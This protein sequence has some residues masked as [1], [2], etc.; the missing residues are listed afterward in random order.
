MDTATGWRTNT[1]TSG[2]RPVS[3]LSPFLVFRHKNRSCYLILK[4]NTFFFILHL[5]S[6]FF[7][8]TDFTCKISLWANLQID[9]T[10][11]KAD[12]NKNKKF[13]QEKELLL[14]SVSPLSCFVSSFIL[15][16]QTNEWSSCFQ[17]YRKLFNVLFS[18]KKRLD[19]CLSLLQYSDK[20]V[21]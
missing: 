14:V 1:S 3:S 10:N 15:L 11:E 19:F 5:I 6:F 20:N 2:C 21:K 4:K 13:G 12:K 8:V 17:W 18:S 16:F 9:Q 7:L